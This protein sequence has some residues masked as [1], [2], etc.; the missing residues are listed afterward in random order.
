LAIFDATVVV[1]VVPDE[2]VGTENVGIEIS[3]VA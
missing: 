3:A 2:V 1:V